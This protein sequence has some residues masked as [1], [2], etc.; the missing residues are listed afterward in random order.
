MD[1]TYFT[2]NVYNNH[3]SIT[4]NGEG[5]IFSSVDK[6]VERTNFPYI[7][8][9]KMI[10]HEGFRN[11]WVVERTGGEIVSGPDL[12]EIVWITNYMEF[13]WNHALKDKEEQE[14]LSAPPLSALRNFKL[15]ET[16]WILQR[17]QEETMLNLAHKFTEQQ[18]TA[19]LIYRQQ[20]R[21]MSLT[22]LTEKTV[23]WPTNPIA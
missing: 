3:A 23:V 12:E 15:Y 9:A 20:L 16:D 4:K 14:A 8:Q 22:G 21:D 1:Y 19:V 2:L 11:N 18:I 13:I 6:F 5:Y 10:H 17:H 7:E